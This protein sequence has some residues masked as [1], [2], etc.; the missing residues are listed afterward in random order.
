MNRMR[1]RRRLRGTILFLSSLSSIL[2]IAFA[3]VAIGV[4]SYRYVGTPWLLRIAAGP[5][6]SVDAEFAAAVQQLGLEHPGLRRVE[7]VKT[8]DPSASA[9]ALDE[10]RADLAIVRT[11][12]PVPK[13]GRT[14]LIV[15]KDAILLLVPPTSRVAKI[16]ELSS[17]R[18]GIIPGSAA[19][20]ALLNAILSHSGVLPPS[21]Q[22]VA[23][24]PAHISDAMEK[25]LVDAVFLLAPLGDPRVDQVVTGLSRGGKLPLR[26]LEL[27]NADAIALR[28]PGLEK[29]QVPTG[30]LQ[31]SPAIP[32]EEAST[33]AISHH[34]M[35][36]S[37]L[38]ESTVAALTGRLLA[39]RALLAGH[40]RVA[41]YM[42]A[43]DTEKGGRYP[44][45]PGAAAY[46]G[47]AEKTFIDRYGDWIYIL[48]MVFGG[49]ASAVATL[50]S[51]VKARARRAAMTLLD[52]LV[53]SQRKAR[54]AQSLAELENYDAT[55]EEIAM[56][57]VNLARENRLDQGGVQAVRLAVDEARH[58]IMKRERDIESNQAAS[59]P[60][61]MVPQRQGDSA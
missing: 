36:R 32:A 60:V 41:E 26:L 4:F 55:V 40:T 57:A 45:H 29:T 33:V 8:E 50:M 59:R 58:S 16:S 21:V 52:E 38:S 37:E 44:L 46:Y 48:A 2:A 27:G 18:I 15:H 39:S 53:E 9:S 12:L 22:Q 35:A 5:S 61:R 30:F 17:K 49:L 23:L 6:G 25:K 54:E 34:L 13:H 56:R 7:L 28:Q 14:I 24:Q 43:A 31:S 1:L 42:T 51:S 19:N 47:D 10:G 11:D 3:A 20:S